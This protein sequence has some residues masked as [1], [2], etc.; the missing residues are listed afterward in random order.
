MFLKRLSNCIYGNKL[1]V[2]T[3]FYCYD[4]WDY[5]FMITVIKTAK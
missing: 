4:Y 2:I 5:K 3:N 1:N